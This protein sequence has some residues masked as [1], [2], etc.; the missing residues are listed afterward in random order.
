STETEKKLAFADCAQIP[1]HKGIETPADV[2][3]IEKIRAMQVD[4]GQVAQKID[5]IQPYLKE[6]AG[7]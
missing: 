4:Y 5:Q 3:K 2:P 7:Q 6:W 1:L